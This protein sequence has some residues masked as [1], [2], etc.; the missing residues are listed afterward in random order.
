MDQN[1]NQLY[2]DDFKIGEV[3]EGEKK[4]LK[5]TDFGIFATLTGDDHPIHYTRID[6]S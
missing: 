6:G 5:N 1:E 4:I 3:Y 2:A